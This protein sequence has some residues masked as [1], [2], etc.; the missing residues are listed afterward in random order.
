MA[1]ISRLLKIIGLFC[2]ISSLLQGSFVKE[3]Y[4]FKEPTN[5]SHPMCMY[6]RTYIHMYVH[7][8]KCVRT[9][10]YVRMS[11]CMSACMYVHRLKFTYVCTHVRAYMRTCIH[12]YARTHVRTY[13]RMYARHESPC[14]YMY[15]PMCMHTSIHV[16]CDA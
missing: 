15:V 6:V 11:A 4:N 9:C 12:A 10:M 3:T 5:H 2:R 13:A 14:A 8:C 1:T 7:I 16:S